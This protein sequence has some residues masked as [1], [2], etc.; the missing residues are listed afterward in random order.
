MYYA[1]IQALSQELI[2]ERRMSGDPGDQLVGGRACRRD[3]GVH[4]R[5]PCVV[6][7]SRSRSWFAMMSRGGLERRPPEKDQKKECKDFHVAAGGAP[8]SLNM[9]PSLKR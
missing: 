9:Y 5:F 3:V 7:Q 8:G 1:T 4:L 6:G 2:R